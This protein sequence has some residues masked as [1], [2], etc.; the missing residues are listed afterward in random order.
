MVSV[1]LIFH[2]L[3]NKNYGIMNTFTFCRKWLLFD[4]VLTIATG[5]YIALLKDTPLFV[6]DEFLNTYF[7]TNTESITQGTQTFMNFCYSLMGVSMAC[8]GVLMYF[9]VKHPF[10]KREKW[11]FQSIVTSIFL[12]FLIDESFSIYYGVYFN[13]L[14]NLPFLMMFA[15]PLFLIRNEF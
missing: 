12:W 15:I 11:A 2:T 1:K 10:A 3:A 6:F 7:W 4:S 5:L 13:A 9:I 8:W 14:F